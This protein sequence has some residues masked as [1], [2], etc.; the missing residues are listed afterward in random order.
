MFALLWI[1]LF[2]IDLL[3]RRGGQIT[4][5]IFASLKFIVNSYGIGY[6]VNQWRKEM[7]MLQLQANYE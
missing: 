7:F 5:S 4:S 6:W 3:F 2:A 1:Y